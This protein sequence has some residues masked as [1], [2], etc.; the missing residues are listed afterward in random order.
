MQYQEHEKKI[1]ECPG[2]SKKYD[3][4]ALDRLLTV[5]SGG[6]LNTILT[7]W[8]ASSDGRGDVSPE[9]RANNAVLSAQAEE[10]LVGIA[11]RVFDL[12]PFPDCL[13]ADALE[14]LTHYLEWMEGKGETARKPQ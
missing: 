10:K 5:T 6:Q 11:R 8:S 9:G 7:E 14:M 1:Y 13:D 3:P 2:N 4:L 12:L